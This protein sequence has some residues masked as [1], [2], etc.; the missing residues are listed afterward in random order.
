[1]GL[2][3]CTCP[4]CGRQFMGHSPSEI[5]SM[6]CRGARVR[7]RQRDA[8]PVTPDSEPREAV[9]RGGR[10][11]AGGSGQRKTDGGWC[12]IVLGVPAVAVATLVALAIRR[13]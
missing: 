11:P 10:G 13:R 4:V 9:S 6:Q 5:C 12:S 8:N 1:M 7:D 2:V 3:P